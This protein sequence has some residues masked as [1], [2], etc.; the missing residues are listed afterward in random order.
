MYELSVFM[1]T[2]RTH[3]HEA[4]LSSLEDSCNRHKFEVVLCGPF[5]P[6]AAVLQKENVT[7]IK[8][9]ASPTVCAQMAMLACKGDYLL[10]LVDDALFVSNSIS[11]EM[12]KITSQ[13]VVGL[14]YNEGQGH[15]GT[16][17]ENE[18]W[19]AGHAYDDWDGIDNSWKL[20]GLFII[21]KALIIKYG[22]FDCIFE[23]FSNAL[24]DLLFR[25]QNTDPAIDFYLSKRVI[26]SV[27]HMPSMTGDHGAM[28][29]A[30]N[31]DVGIFRSFWHLTT[32]R[33]TVDINNFN[34]NEKIWSFRFKGQETK[35]EDLV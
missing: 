24:T 25:I 6:P 11:D 26:C 12:D 30:N 13:S 2:I 9:F 19:V 23:Y 35:Y 16:E 7:W 4:W 21:P 1:P 15:T 32:D 28:H 31:K 18:R 17:L 20:C 3:L 10:H 5:E 29:M 27:D 14:R 33:S 34:N 8:S 22:G